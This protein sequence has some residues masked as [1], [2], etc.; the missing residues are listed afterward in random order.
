MKHYRNLRA[1]IE[2]DMVLAPPLT[3]KTVGRE[4]LHDTFNDATL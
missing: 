1:R 3:D 2:T 4:R